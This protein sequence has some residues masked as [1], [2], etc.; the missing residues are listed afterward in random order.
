MQARGL[1]RKVARALAR[2]RRR[3]GAASR[4][5]GMGSANGDGGEGSVAWRGTHWRRELSG[6]ARGGGGAR[7]PGGYFGSLSSSH[8]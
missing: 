3:G 5:G 7:R 4:G 1:G 6:Y 8:R 2:A